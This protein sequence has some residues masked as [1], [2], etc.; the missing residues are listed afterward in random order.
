[1]TESF[2]LAMRVFIFLNVKC[3]CTWGVSLFHWHPCGCHNQTPLHTVNILCLLSSKQSV[4][5][6]HCSSNV[7]ITYVSFQHY[8]SLFKKWKLAWETF[9]GLCRDFLLL[10]IWYIIELEWLPML[11]RWACLVKSNTLWEIIYIYTHTYWTISFSFENLFHS[12]TSQ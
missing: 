4:K 6:G 10:L 3:M 7:K 11:C 12:Y 1:M 8:F 2:F 9:A 5:L